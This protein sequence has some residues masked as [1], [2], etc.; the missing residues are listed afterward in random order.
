MMQQP[1]LPASP[2]AVANDLRPRVHRSSLS[3][4]RHESNEGRGFRFLRP[5]KTRPKEKS[6]SLGRNVRPEEKMIP[7]VLGEMYVLKKRLVNPGVKCRLLS[8]SFKNLSEY[9]KYS[10]TSED[11]PG[12]CA[13]NPEARSKYLKYPSPH[14]LSGLGES[15]MH[16]TTQNSGSRHGHAPE[17]HHPRAHRHKRT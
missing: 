14:R 11:D 16:N 5:L 4:T 17:V 13:S 3:S 15:R 8:E 12:L 9:F 6:I 2:R 1:L 7:S 10:R